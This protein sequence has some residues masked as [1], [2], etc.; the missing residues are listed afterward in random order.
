VKVIVRPPDEAMRLALSRHA[1]RD[2]ID[3]DRA[4]LQH[5]AF[6]G[7]LEAAGVE[8]VRLPPEPGM[9]DATF[10]SDALLA[11]RRADR[12]D[13][14]T[15]V[16]VAARPGAPSRRGE[17]ASVVRAARSVTGRAVPVARIEDPGTLDGGDVVIFGE[18][19]AIGISA[20]TNRAGAEQ[21]AE[22]ARSL[23]YGTFACPVEDRLH[24]ASAVTSLRPTRLIGT[25]AGFASLDAAHPSPAAPPEVE[26]IFLPDEEVAGANVLALGGRVFVAAG[27]PCASELLGAAGE[28]VVEVSIDE[29]TRAD[30]GPTCLVAPVP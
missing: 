23:G 6:T 20:R 7:A 5:Q 27:N 24:L 2:R 19:M 25:S 1:E 28:S 18:R 13:G 14:R 4:R 29:F 15:A 16:L 12:P 10:V 11:L 22:V 30:G 26:R 17:V 3:P 9:P 21:L 8:L